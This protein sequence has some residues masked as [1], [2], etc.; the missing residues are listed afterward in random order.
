MTTELALR[1]PTQTEV[2]Q[3]EAA[4]E[5]LPALV[6]SGDTETLNE[7]S[8]RARLA[9]LYEA[10]NGHKEMADRWGRLKITAEAGIG[11]VDVALHPRSGDGPLVIKGVEVTQSVRDRWRTL[12]YAD[13]QGLLTG[14]LD[15][16]AQDP[17]ASLNSRD[18]VT[19]AAAA[20][21]GT[22]D[23]GPLRKAYAKQKSTLTQATIAEDA[24]IP[25]GQ[26]C[27]LL[28]RPRSSAKGPQRS[29]CYRQ[30]LALAET[31]GVAPRSL[32]V[33]PSY[34]GRHTRKRRKK[35]V[36]VRSVTTGG[37]WDKAYVA[38]RKALDEFGQIAGE[39]TKYDET[40]AHYY[41]LEDYLAKQIKRS[42]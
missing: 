25:V 29:V 20:G 34:K 3:I 38:L 40:Y 16:A 14:L 33:A 2:A 26:V 36:A 1:A 24:G 31:L 19:R 6:D 21:A 35:L 8:E 17:D 18:V 13:L 12:G 22:W 30:G 15:D 28:S 41:A 27:R 23:L 4:E 11:A 9:Q 39:D 37:A 7:V 5:R 32:Q 10:R 42:K